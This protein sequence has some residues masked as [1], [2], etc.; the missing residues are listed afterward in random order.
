MFHIAH[1]ICVAAGFFALAGSR[2]K[3]GGGYLVW[4]DVLLKDRCPGH[5]AKKTRTSRC[6]KNGRVVRKCAQNYTCS[7]T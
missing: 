4:R 7:S 2:V 5:I 6:P 3:R 1:D